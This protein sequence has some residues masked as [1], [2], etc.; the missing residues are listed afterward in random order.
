M[1]SYWPDLFPVVVIII[2]II[3]FLV[4]RHRSRDEERSLKSQIHAFQEKTEELSKG[5][6]T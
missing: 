3:A 4:F 5:E 6:D 2:M 1:N